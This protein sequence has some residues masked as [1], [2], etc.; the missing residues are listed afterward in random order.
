MNFIKA[1]GIFN[2]SSNNTVD[3]YVERGKNKDLKGNHQGAVDEYTKAIELSSKTPDFL[4]F[5]IANLF[6]MR[7]LSKL[8]LGDNYGALNDVQTTVKIFPDYYADAYY[9]IGHI[10]AKMKNFDEAIENFSTAIDIT[11]KYHGEYPGLESDYLW[12]AY[13]ERGNVK[14]ILS[15][16]QESIEDCTKAIKLKP[17]QYNAYRGRAKGKFFLKDYIGSVKDYT[18]AIELEPNNAIIYYE[19]SK[20]Y[21][22]LIELNNNHQNYLSM[23]HDLDKTLI[24]NPSAVD[25]LSNRGALRAKL[26]DSKGAIQDFKHLLKLE[27]NNQDV[28]TLLKSLLEEQ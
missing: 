22:K 17:K 15:N 1:F 10:E 27:P 20:V 7:A 26:G 8:E 11:H 2:K 9:L 28:R 24:L 25:A 16:F 23:L 19:R 14:C 13:V 4:K 12:K 6:I 5:R 21:A 3:D 18:K